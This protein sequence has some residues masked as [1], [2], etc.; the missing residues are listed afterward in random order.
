MDDS[1][2][3][4]SLGSMEVAKCMYFWSSVKI[5][6]AIRTE[7][8]RRDWNVV[9]VLQMF[10]Y[11][12]RSKIVYFILFSFLV[13]WNCNHIYYCTPGSHYLDIK[14]KKF[15]K[16]KINGSY[17]HHLNFF[18]LKRLKII[19]HLNFVF[20]FDTKYYY[21]VGIGYTVR[22]FWFKTPPSFGT[23]PWFSAHSL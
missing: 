18:E 11:S 20:Q 16:A 19:Y 9:E 5:F 17:M 10:T 4:C 7:Y 12:L 14:K 21:V 1:Y 6:V 8:Q 15:L 23:L 2:Y 13:F 3:I 22:R